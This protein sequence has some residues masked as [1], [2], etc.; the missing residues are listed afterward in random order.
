MN[1]QKK[2]QQL[3]KAKAKKASAKLAPKSK[4]K[5]ISKADRLKL[6]TEAGENPVTPLETPAE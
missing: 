2:L 3:F 1:R 5:Y 4:D 6:A